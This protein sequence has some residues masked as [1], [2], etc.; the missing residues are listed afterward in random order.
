MPETSRDAAGLAAVTA[1]LLALGRQLDRAGLALT[2]A[3]LLAL[4]LAPLPWMAGAALLGVVLLGLAEH[5]FA[6]R[7][8]FDVPVFAA[9]ARLWRQ[10][11]AE[12]ETDLA[13][14]DAALASLGLRPSAEG[15]LRSLQARARGARRLLG[16]QALC[17]GLQVAGWLAAVSLLMIHR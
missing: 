14:F 2:A 10:G 7:T 1:A 8:A 6:L 13:D 16:R 17:L 12:P 15:P 9:W 4:V 5:W 11:D 3:A